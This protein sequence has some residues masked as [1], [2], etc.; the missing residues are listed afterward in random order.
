MVN[1][2]PDG[3]R[4]LGGRAFLL[5][6]NHGCLNICR[7]KIGIFGDDLII[8]VSGVLVSSN[9]GRWNTCP[10]D[11]TSI[12]NYVSRSLDPANRIRVARAHP[13][14]VSSHTSSNSS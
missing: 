9:S 5:L 1:K 4:P 14:Y 10:T 12:T 8:G 6:M 13:C 3:P 11:H 7:S 2:E